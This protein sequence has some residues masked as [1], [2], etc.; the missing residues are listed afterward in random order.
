[1]V[2]KYGEGGKGGLSR[3]SF[4]T[5][6]FYQLFVLLR[7]DRL[8]VNAGGMCWHLLGMRRSVD[9]AIQEQVGDRVRV[10]EP[11]NRRQ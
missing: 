9:L 4:F 3:S 6:I 8:S 2:V 10:A 1:M 11:A 5:T 7:I